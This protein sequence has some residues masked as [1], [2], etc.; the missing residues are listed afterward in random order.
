MPR[1]SCNV[2]SKLRA[3]E[4]RNSLFDAIGDSLVKGVKNPNFSYVGAT[5]AKIGLAGDTLG[6]AHTTPHIV[7][8][9]GKSII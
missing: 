6:V 1:I 7:G 4:G 9:H 8:A 3:Y 5:M 2:L